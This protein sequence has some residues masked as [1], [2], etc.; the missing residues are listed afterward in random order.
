M[1]S[2]SDD[3]QSVAEDERSEGMSLLL[4]GAQVADG[5]R[6]GK[7]YG[8]F[9]PAGGLGDLDG[10]LLRR[11]CGDGES[12]AVAGGSVEQGRLED[13]SVSGWTC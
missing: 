2:G 1:N 7:G 12:G 6:V 9:G 11:Q 8:E 4:V 10:L 13:L 5:E 3:S